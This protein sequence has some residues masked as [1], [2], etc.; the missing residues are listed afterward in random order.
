M[1]SF[2]E[3]R[4]QR[5]KVSDVFFRT[6]LSWLEVCLRVLGWDHCYFLLLIDDLQ[7]DCLVHKSVDDTTL[8][9]LLVSGDHT[10]TQ[11]VESLR[12]WA[13]TNKMI[14]NRSKSKEMIIGSFAKQPIPCLT[15]ETDVIERVRPTTVKLLGVTL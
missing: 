6:G 1:F 12:T 8:S 7:L 15:V 10:M 3:G 13:Q 4:Q 5:V 9:E 14:I 2:L 11:Y